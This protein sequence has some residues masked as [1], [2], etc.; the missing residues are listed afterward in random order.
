VD[1]CSA[2]LAAERLEQDGP[3]LELWFLEIPQLE[4]LARLRHDHGGY[5]GYVSFIY[6][7]F[8]E[9]YAATAGASWS[10][11]ADN[12]PHVFASTL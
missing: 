6:L 2:D 10:R 11:I 5:H 9:G 7:I 8:N 3:W 12:T 4:R 1:V